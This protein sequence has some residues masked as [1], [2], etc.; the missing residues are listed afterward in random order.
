[1]EVLGK[2]RQEEENGM[3]EQ[4]ERRWVRAREADSQTDCDTYSRK[5]TR[6]DNHWESSTCAKPWEEEASKALGWIVAQ[7]QKLFGAAIDN[8]DDNAM[9]LPSSSS[10]SPQT[11]PL[12]R[13]SNDPQV[14]HLSWA[15]EEHCVRHC[16]PRTCLG[17]PLAMA[18]AHCIGRRLLRCFLWCT[19]SMALTCLSANQTQPPS[20]R[21]SNSDLQLQIEYCLP[22]DL[23]REISVWLCIIRRNRSW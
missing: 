21:T 3:T 12:L 15:E 1:M 14:A 2:Q 11:T 18:M 7:H 17:W 5:A 23:P 9:R 19:A 10:V 22:S 20:R 6:R 13:P 4:A 8:C 16:T